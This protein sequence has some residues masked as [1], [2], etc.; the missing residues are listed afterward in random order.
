VAVGNEP[1]LKAYN[2]SF[3]KTTFPALK[4]VQKALDEAGIGGSVK[5]VV[6]LN[7]DVYVSPDDKPSSGAFRP[8]INDLMT[9]IVKFLH[10]HGA[11][12]VVN[13]Y[14]F[15]SLALSDNFPFE[16]AFFDGGRNIQDKD[17]ISYTNVFDANYDTLVHALTKAGVPNLK[18]IVGE[19]GWPTDGET[20]A[21]LKLARRFYDGL[22]KKLAKNEG[23]PLRPGRLEVYLFGLFDED[24]KSIAPGNFERHWGILTYDGKPKF[25]IDLTGQGH[26]KL[27]AAVPDVQYL[28]SQW[29]V[30]DDKA[31]DQS[32]KLPGNLQYACASGDCTALGYG[33]SCNGLDEK[34]NISYAFNMYFQM[35]DQ[36]VRACD[37]D[38]LAKITDKNA[39]TRGCLFPIQIV[40]AG[41]RTAPVF[42]WVALWAFAVMLFV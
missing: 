30:F 26:D 1:F 38:G 8:D 39:S 40:S 32:G 23:T 2:G 18:I 10:D 25:P 16:F 13:I 12:F 20:N 29:C 17:G 34:S 22:L 9:D 7:A 27:L 21:N 41:G 19:A 5:A 11:P 42:L 15:L 24:L 31:K 37:F 14:P 28:P 36:D 3:M 35:Q 4:N 33:S 6:P